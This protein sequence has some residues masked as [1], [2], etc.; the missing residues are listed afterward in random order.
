[1][2]TGYEVAIERERATSELKRLRTY[3]L[4]LSVI[5]AYLL[6]NEVERSDLRRAVF[7]RLYGV[8][9]ERLAPLLVSPRL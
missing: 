5:F 9:A 4:S 8:P 1:S 7:G 6:R 3:P 2:L